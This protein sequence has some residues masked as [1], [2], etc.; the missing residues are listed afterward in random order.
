MGGTNSKTGRG[1]DGEWYQRPNHCQC[2]S[3]KNYTLWKNDR[4]EAKCTKCGLHWSK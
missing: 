2:P 4:G 1:R 3:C